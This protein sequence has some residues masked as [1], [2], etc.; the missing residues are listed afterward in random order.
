MPLQWVDIV[1]NS[2]LE[3]TKG[4]IQDG[5]TSEIILRIMFYKYANF[6]AFVRKNPWLL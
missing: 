5:S 2:H 6:H 4:Q 3:V 1:D